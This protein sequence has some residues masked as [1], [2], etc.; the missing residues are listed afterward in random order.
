[1]ATLNSFADA[2]RAAAA[3]SNELELET[4]TRKSFEEIFS[5]SLK[6]ALARVNN[7][8]VDSYDLGPWVISN[9]ILLADV[10]GYE[11]SETMAFLRVLLD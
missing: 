8:T 9:L 4:G 11:L 7:G 5:E 3:A 1:M 10:E 2:L 6:D